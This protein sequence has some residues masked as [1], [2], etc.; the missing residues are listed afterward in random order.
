L[1]T[2]GYSLSAE[3]RK[4]KRGADGKT[5]RIKVEEIVAEDPKVGDAVE[6]ELIVQ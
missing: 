2:A 1:R 6:D 3:T 5:Y 4:C